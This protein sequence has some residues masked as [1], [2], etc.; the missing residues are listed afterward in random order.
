MLS[1]F[2]TVDVECYHGDYD[3]EVFARG[4]GLEFLLG[5]FNRRRMA[6]TCFVEAL[7]ATRWGYE[8]VRRAC[9]SVISTGCEVGLHLHPVVADIEGFTDSDDILH[10]HGED[11]QARLISTGLEVLAKCNAGN[12][13]SFRAGDL[14]ADA[15]TL[16]A[17]KSTGL[18][19]GSNRDLDQKTSTRS[20]LNDVFP[21]KND[22]SSIHG[23]TD[24]PVTAFRSAV[25]RLDGRYR[26]LQI[27]AVSAGETIFCLRKMAETGYR[28]ATIL[29]H[30]GEF[31]RVRRGVFLP[32]NKNI[33]RLRCIL[34]FLAG[35]TTFDVR[36]V[37]S[38]VDMAVV[39]RS[40]TSGAAEGLF[41][42]PDIE[43]PLGLS[44]GRI[45]EQAMER[46]RRYIYE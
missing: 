26:H 9:S 16:R 17:M 29:M 15:A 38:C 21:V 23:V 42:P 36:F 27:T 12:V 31:F 7:G 24:L 10:A 8:G 2:L 25:P 32:N 35:E 13:R 40:G 43:M 39:G 19:L 18:G 37:S 14:A 4:L 20:K 30:P 3:R 41:S 44:A 46:V 11:V 34:D 5:E 28:T 45:A 22:L 33:R 6:A 1:V